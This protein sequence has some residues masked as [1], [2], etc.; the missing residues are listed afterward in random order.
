V[1]WQ[2]GKLASAKI[3][4]IQGGSKKVSVRYG[5]VTENIELK[6]GTEIVLNHELQGTKD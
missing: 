2:D 3:K 5:G 6:P 1:T 4:S